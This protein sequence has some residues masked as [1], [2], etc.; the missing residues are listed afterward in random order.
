MTT[1]RTVE[2]FTAGCSLCEEAVSLISRIACPSC[3]VTVNSL[4]NPKGRERA[5]SL[6][7]N[8]VPAFAV[9]GELAACCA[10]GS[11][12]EPGL[13]AAGVGEPL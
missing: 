13:R 7:V 11:A 3:F 4:K 8:S 9:D 5:R 2:I 10:V 6:G 1:K 12:D